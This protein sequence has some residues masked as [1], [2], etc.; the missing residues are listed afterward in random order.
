M[1]CERQG[2]R[3]QASEA[4]EAETRGALWSLPDGQ[5]LP[6]LV[7]ADPWWWGIPPIRPASSP[8]IWRTPRD[9]TR[10]SRPGCFVR[11]ESAARSG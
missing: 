4:R 3:R 9:S 7:E 10:A 1:V 2:E 5:R 6:N 8:R 11:A